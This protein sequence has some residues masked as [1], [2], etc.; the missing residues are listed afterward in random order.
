MLMDIFI[1]QYQNKIE[2]LMIRGSKETL[3]VKEMSLRVQK[4]TI[5]VVSS[6]KRTLKLEKWRRHSVLKIG[7]SDAVFINQH[8][9]AVYIKVTPWAGE[10]EQV[11]VISPTLPL[12]DTVFQKMFS[13]A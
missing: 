3:S 13:T 5:N 6:Q 7:P 8:A 11:T 10:L 4:E 9:K 12:F 2:I 1:G